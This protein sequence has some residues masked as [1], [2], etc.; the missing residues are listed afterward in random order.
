MTLRVIE[1]RTVRQNRLQAFVSLDLIACVKFPFVSPAVIS[2]FVEILANFG[3]LVR[4]D[5][6]H[7]AID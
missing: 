1:L 4:L 7:T 2:V 6:R 3:G 5:I